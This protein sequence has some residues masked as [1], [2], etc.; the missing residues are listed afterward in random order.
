MI[1]HPFPIVI[2]LGSNL[3]PGPE[4]FNLAY[5]LL[6]RGGVRVMARSRIY[7][8][9]PWG[10]N[11]QPVFHN[12]AITVRTSLGPLALLDR[13]LTIEVQLGRRRRMRWGPR[14]LDLDLILYGTLHSR[15]SGL[16]LPHPYIAQRDFVLAPL[17]D[18]GVPPPTAIAPRG[19]PAL[20]ARIPSTQR[21][22]IQAQPWFMA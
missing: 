3:G 19:W 4:T 6:E 9:H 21:T 1:H 22:L 8:S 11:D 7:W 14:R 2:A 20:M 10:V 18:L 13:C 15:R 16:N 5:R 12:A 17:I